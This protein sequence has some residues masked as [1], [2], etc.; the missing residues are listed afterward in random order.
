[1]STLL[2]DH[3]ILRI[4]LST[5]KSRNHIPFIMN[6]IQIDRFCIFSHNVTK[7]IISKRKFDRI[8]FYF[9]YVYCI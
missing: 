8:N 9:G 6:I 7:N 5:I 3:V 2:L 1:M 4:T